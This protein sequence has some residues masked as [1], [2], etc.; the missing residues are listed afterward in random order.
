MKILV[1]LEKEYDPFVITISDGFGTTEISV[2]VNVLN[3]V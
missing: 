1:L 3:V 2:S